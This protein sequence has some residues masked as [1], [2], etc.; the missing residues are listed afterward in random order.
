MNSECLRIA[1][2]LRNAFAG[3]PWHGSPLRELLAGVTAEQARAC[4]IPGAH[5]IWELVLHI[6]VWI[7]AASGATQGIPMPKLYRTEKDWQFVTEADAT[8]WA[9]AT[10]H[11]FQSA[12]QL[13]HAIEGFSDERL[14]QTVPGCTYDFYYL[15]H[16]IVQHSLYHG[17]QIALLGKADRS[18]VA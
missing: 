11:L 13:A 6:D 1:S 15:F 2:Q 8:A 9:Q 18:I 14:H 17:G 10:D 3:E 7:E 4:P 12:G 16:G 5:S